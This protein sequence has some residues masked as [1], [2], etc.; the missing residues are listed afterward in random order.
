MKVMISAEEVWIFC[1]FLNCCKLASNSERSSAQLLS[2]VTY[3][4]ALYSVISISKS[5]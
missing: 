4:K 1:P 5:L 2:F 3:S